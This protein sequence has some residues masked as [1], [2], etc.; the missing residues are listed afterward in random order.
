M[1]I[2]KAP[3]NF[4]PLNSDVVTPYWADHISHDLP[5]EDGQSGEIEVTLTTHS[6]LFIRDGKKTEG[7]VQQF[8]QTE[9]GKYFIPG[10]SLKGMIRSVM[11]VMTFSKMKL[12]NNHRFAYRDF[13]NNQLYQVS[14][15]S[16][17]AECGWMKIDE[18][19]DYILEECGKP[20]RVHMRELEKLK[21]WELIKE[22]H[23]SFDYYSFF[24]KG[25]KGFGFDGNSDKHKSAKFKYEKLNNP[26]PILELAKVDRK[27]SKYDYRDKYTLE[28]LANQDPLPET[29]V[30]TLVLT[31][32]PDARKPGNPEKKKKPSGKVFE[33]VFLPPYNTRNLTKESPDEK[34]KVIED[35]EWA[36]LDQ[37]NTEEQSIDW[38]YFKRRLQQGEKIPVFYHKEGDEIESMGLSLLYKFA[39]NN[40]VKELI[41]KR[42][43]ENDLSM[44][45][46]IFGHIQENRE[47]QPALK[48]RVHIE[49]A[50]GQEGTVELEDQIWKE[51]LSSPKASYYPI[52]VRQSVRKNQVSVYKTYN[53]GFATIS[54]RKRYPIRNFGTIHN[55]PSKKVKN[56][57]K[58]TTKFQPLKKGTFTFSIRYHNLKKVEL[59]ALISA[60][61]FHNHPRAFHS[62]GMGKPLGLGKVKLSVNNIDDYSDTLKSFEAFMCATLGYDWS[63][64]TEVRELITMAC[65][66]ENTDRHLR[67]M[68]LDRQDFANAK[69]KREGLPSYSKL[70]GVTV[71][72]IK[73]LVSKEDVEKAKKMIAA[74]KQLYQQKQSTKDFIQQKLDFYKEEL[75]SKLN[76]HKNRLKNKL[77][78]QREEIQ[79]KIR[80]SKKKAKKEKA[81]KKGPEFSKVD[82][83]NRD[84]FDDQLK[85]IMSTYSS[86]LYPSI[87]E[88]NLPKEKPEGWLPEDFHQELEKLVLKI[89]QNSNKN[90]KKKWRRDFKKNAKLKKVREWIGETKAK[91]LLERIKNK[92]M[93]K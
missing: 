12:V 92:E 21:D 43:T 42:Q 44:V 1:A 91:E 16:K 2:V 66:H 46:S 35:M 74:E 68:N 89:V 86:K 30:G 4:V 9:E 37:K 17:T 39:Y 48:G 38:I 59:G 88:K 79:E 72:R 77:K 81:Q 87:K 50:F 76:E 90:E 25:K 10:S 63:E 62:L 18:N 85:K 32:Q 73:S 49:H 20:G 6:P 52:Y 45:E 53:D 40:S 5:F 54:G 8:C 61:T 28:G 34:P 31:G 13:H 23:Q 47:S 75:K 29:T 33:F 65:E 69:K 58:V 24:T 55:P 60:I 82:P 84:A 7:E 57:D 11:E 64:S 67:Y 26:H 15:I 14:G 78:D 83:E 36:Y 19:G 22:E 51:V 56:P 41:E 27:G 3:Y 93:K 71:T 80:K 70:E